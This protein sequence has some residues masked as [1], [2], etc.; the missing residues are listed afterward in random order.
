MSLGAASGAIA[1][2][3]KNVVCQH[4]RADSSAFGVEMVDRVEMLIAGEDKLR[5]GTGNL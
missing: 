4:A 2:L 5:S 3:G 1:K